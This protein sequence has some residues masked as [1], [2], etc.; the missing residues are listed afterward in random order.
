MFHMSKIII[1][2]RPERISI[3]DLKKILPDLKEIF[4]EHILGH[5]IHAKRAKFYPEIVSDFDPDVSA[6]AFR[7]SC[8]LG[9]DWRQRIKK[10][11]QYICRDLCK[12]ELFKFFGNKDKEKFLKITH[13]DSYSGFF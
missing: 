9:D 2:Y 10:I 6:I 11:Q 13:E 1:E 8:D 7:V 4:A 5:R 3:H 12:L